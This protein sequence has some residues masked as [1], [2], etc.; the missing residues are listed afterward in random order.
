MYVCGKKKKRKLI[1]CY[2]IPVFQVKKKYEIFIIK[3]K[4]II[5]KWNLYKKINNNLKYY[6]W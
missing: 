4:K 3:R 2:V 5:I 1:K 6:N